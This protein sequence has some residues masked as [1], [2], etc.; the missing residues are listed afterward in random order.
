MP[1]MCSTTCCCN[2][3]WTRGWPTTMKTLGSSSC[4]TCWTTAFQPLMFCNGLIIRLLLLLRCCAGLRLA[5]AVVLSC[6]WA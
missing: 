4:R 2:R 1:A 3:L 5:V 6:W